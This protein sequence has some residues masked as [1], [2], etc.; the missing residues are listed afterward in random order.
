LPRISGNL[1]KEERFYRRVRSGPQRQAQR[2]IKKPLRN[3][4]NLVLRFFFVIAVPHSVIPAQAG[5]QS[6]WIPFVQAFLSERAN[7]MTKYFWAWL[8]NA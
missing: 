6:F 2:E 4:A 3:P 1:E 5:I 7:G 8:K